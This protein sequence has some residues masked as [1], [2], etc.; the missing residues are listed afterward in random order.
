M[1]SSIDMA[2][3]AIQR[4]LNQYKARRLDGWHGGG[5]SISD[6]FQT[7]LNSIDDDED[8]DDSSTTAVDFVDPEAK[9]IT[10][11]NSFDLGKAISL[12]EAVFALDYVDHDFYIFLNS[13]TN[14][15]TTIY[16]RHAGGIGLIEP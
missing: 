8:G 9:S 3:Q 6:D 1:Y 16:K 12:E 14:K 10:K 13:A 4:K 7:A 11:V 15:I 5:T 2:A